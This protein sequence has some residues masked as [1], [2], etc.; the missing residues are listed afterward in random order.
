M[1]N[2]QEWRDTRSLFERQFSNPMIRSYV[3]ILTAKSRVMMNQLPTARSN[4]R[5]FSCAKPL[6]SF[7]VSFSERTSSRKLQTMARRS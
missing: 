7:R 6:M 5:P 3:P 2:G 1:A 4:C